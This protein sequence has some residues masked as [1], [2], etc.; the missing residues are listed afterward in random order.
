MSN[1]VL[2]DFKC[3]FHGSL[4]NAVLKAFSRYEIGGDTGVKFVTFENADDK[5]QDF[6]KNTKD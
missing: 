1:A 3:S 4:E 2:I 5:V 6:E